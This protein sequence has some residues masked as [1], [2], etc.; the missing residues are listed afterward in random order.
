[1][2]PPRR[3]ALGLSFLFCALAL[4]CGL[5]SRPAEAAALEVVPP[6]VL[7]MGNAG[8]AAASGT[9]GP[10]LNPSGISLVRSYVV[11][12]AYEYLS[13]E[14]GN[15]F[16]AVI[17]DSTSGSNVG[18]GLRYTYANAA[19]AG[20]WEGAEALSRHEIGLSLSFPFNDHVAIGATGR[21]LRTART[22]PGGSEEKNTGITYDAGI[23][24]RP[25]S[26]FSIGFVGYGLRDMK[27][28]QAP[29]GYGGGIALVPMPE[30]VLVADAAV[31]LRRYVP[32]GGDQRKAV[33]ISGGAEYTSAARLAMRAG[34]GRDGLRR[35]GFGTLGASVLSES[36]ALDVGGRLDFNEGDKVWMIGVSLRLFVPAP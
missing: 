32:E 5:A 22:L 8:R 36:G 3:L 15:A 35:A 16:H 19:P 26:I 7:G 13:A 10:T 29:F 21:Y 31:D 6:R 9:A 18:G 20:T 14:Q 4:A 34:G 17:A 12:G 28:P 33:T 25:V 27:D 24:I 2:L 23:T 1:M 11:E 30:F